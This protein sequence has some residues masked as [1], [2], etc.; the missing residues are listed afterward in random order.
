M[1]SR[2][3]IPLFLILVG[4]CSN[5]L[6]ASKCTHFE[7]NE[8]QSDPTKYLQPHFRSLESIKA[9]ATMSL[10]E[11]MDTPGV[12]ILD[13]GGGYGL[14]GLE[15][16]LQ[17]QKS[18]TVINSQN[19]W[20]HFKS[21]L[22]GVESFEVSRETMGRNTLFKVNGVPLTVI[23]QLS[24]LFNEKVYLHT[25]FEDSQRSPSK[26]AELDQHISRLLSKLEN[27]KNFRY[28]PGYSE[29]VMGKLSSSFDVI[30]D[31]YGA[32][33]YSPNRLQLLRNYWQKLAP[34]GAAYIVLGSYNWVNDP[35]K[36]FPPKTL[37]HREIELYQDRVLD[38]NGVEKNFIEYLTSRLPQM[39]TEL[40]I[41]KGLLFLVIEKPYYNSRRDLLPHLKNH[42]EPS[43]MGHKEKNFF[44]PVMTY[45]EK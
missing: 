41:D 32:F 43:Y 42:S 31:F 30:L 6:A 38:R 5:V 19:F 44:Y 18:A 10:L 16:S 39:R 37:N 28:V 11:H 40:A 24:R 25:D 3:L 12:R 33:F 13:S 14:A 45:K 4:P 17:K 34:G 26:K 21:R 22:L 7:V 20:G 27:H 23:E 15:L 8:T 36:N 2:I 29:H 1:N 9:F 35:N